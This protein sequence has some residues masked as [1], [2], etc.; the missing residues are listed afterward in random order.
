MVI[1]KKKLIEVWTFY[2]LRAKSSESKIVY[3]I[4]MTDKILLCL[5]K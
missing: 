3:T 4:K 1:R 2:D 5:C